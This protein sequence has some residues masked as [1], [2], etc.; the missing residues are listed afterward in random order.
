[1][2]HVRKPLAAAVILN[3]TI[4]IGEAVAGIKAQSLSLIMDSVHNLSDELALVF[5]FMA[6]ILPITLSRN[7]QRAAN[8]FNSVGLIGISIVVVWQAIERIISPTLV[9]G[10]V[11]I[12]VGILAAIANWGVAYFLK[13]I[14]NQNAA[15][16]LAYLHNLGDVFVSLAPAA[17][18][19]LILITGRNI[20]DPL[21][22][23]GIAI[24]IIWSTLKE[25][26]ISGNKLIWPE[27]A[28]CKHD[29]VEKLE[30]IHLD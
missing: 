8:L 9:F 13:D 17:A 3:T 21:I 5:L 6:Y 30:S 19:L 15:I 22:A 28:V 27:N 23:T 24:W 18:G 16:R 29:S 25:I 4:F 7:F 12:I 11:P 2:S 10:L 14:R 26:K 20:F 1:M